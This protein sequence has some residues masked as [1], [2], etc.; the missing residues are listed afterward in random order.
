MK[1]TMR[2]VFS[3]MVVLFVGAVSF[4]ILYVVVREIKTIIVNL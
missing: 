2:H 1:Q 4:L 3:W